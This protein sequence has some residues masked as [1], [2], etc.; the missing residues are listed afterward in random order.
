MQ[1]L[2][3]SLN[4]LSASNLNLPLGQKTHVPGPAPQSSLCAPP[5][6]PSQLRQFLFAVLLYFQS[7]ASTTSPITHWRFATGAC[8]AVILTT[9]ILILV[10]SI[11]HHIVSS[12]L[13]LGADQGSIQDTMIAAGDCLRN[14]LDNLCNHLLQVHLESGQFH[15]ACNWFSSILKLSHGTVVAICLTCLCLALANRAIRACALGCLVLRLPWFAVF[16]GGLSSLVLKAPSSTITAAAPMALSRL[17][18]AHR[19]IVARNGDVTATAVGERACA[20][21]CAR[22]CSISN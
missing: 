16:A 4:L 17:R 13:A 19:A 18:F 14:L 6:H 1:S 3:V 9:Q 20:A 22:R 5:G 2:Q 7:L 15:S 10:D 11:T 21:S 8:F 12:A